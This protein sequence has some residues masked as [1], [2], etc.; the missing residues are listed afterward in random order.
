MSSSLGRSA[1]ERLQA[2]KAVVLRRP[3]RPQLKIGVANRHSAMEL[4]SV[5][6]IIGR[7]LQPME[8]HRAQ[9]RGTLWLLEVVTCGFRELAWSW[10]VLA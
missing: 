6:D 8:K 1:S 9:Y 2:G 7:K 3:P 4:S 5:E 10:H